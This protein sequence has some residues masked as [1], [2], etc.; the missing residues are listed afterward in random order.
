MV[1]NWRN[2][3]GVLYKIE[4]KKE[5]ENNN[6]FYWPILWQYKNDGFIKQ[7]ND[8][9]WCLVV[10]SIRYFLGL[11]NLVKLVCFTFPKSL[12]QLGTLGI[13][14]GLFYEQYCLDVQKAI[15]KNIIG[16]LLLSY[17]VNEFLIIFKRKI[18]KVIGLI[19]IF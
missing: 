16:L 17:W 1:W 7:E 14:V 19:L 6:Q 15:R 2:L 3:K 4:R 10:G 12:E 8:G 18:Y 11:K 5:K 9:Y 13:P